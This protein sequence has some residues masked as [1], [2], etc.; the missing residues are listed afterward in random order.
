MK[1]IEEALKKLNVKG[2]I[3]VRW[4][5]TDRIAVYVNN[6]YFGIWDTVRKT[7]VD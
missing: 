5:A 2:I 6:K 7:F 1:E 3:I 4:I